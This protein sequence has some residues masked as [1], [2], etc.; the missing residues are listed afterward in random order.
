MVQLSKFNNTYAP[1]GIDGY[2]L[3][4]LEATESLVSISS[5]V[6]ADVPTT[7]IVRQYRTSDVTTIVQTNSTDVPA[8]T[9]QVVQFAIKSAFY[10]VSILNQSGGTAATVTQLTT[11]LQQ[12][13]YVN[14]DIRPL[15]ATG[16]KV[17]NV[18]SCGV[19][20]TGLSHPIA[21]DA[22]GNLIVIT[23]GGGGG[24][25]HVI[26]D[27]FPAVT[28][29]SGSVFISG[30]DPVTHLVSQVT[31]GSASV[32]GIPYSA[33]GVSMTAFNDQNSGS[34]V[35]C[36][37]YDPSGEQI[38]TMNI[39]PSVRYEDCTGA[40]V[41]TG[42]VTLTG[43]ALVTG[44]MP[45]Y[46]F[47]PSVANN[48]VAIYADGAQGTNVTGGWSYTNT[49]IAG[50]KINWYVYSSAAAPSDIVGS[51]LLSQYAVISQATALQNPFIVTYTRPQAT[52][53]SA[54]WYK[55][56]YFWGSNAGAT[57]LGMKL[58]YS[59]SDP[60]GIHP[61]IIGANRIQLIF[62]PSLSTSAESNLLSETVYL[63]TLMT[64]SLALAGDFNFIFGEY[65]VTLSPTPVVLPIIANMVQTQ[66]A[67]P[68][69]A[70]TNALGSVSVSNLPAVQ[71]VG[72]LF[73]STTQYPLSVDASGQLIIS[74][75]NPVLCAG[76]STQ[77][78]ANH[79]L[80]TTTAGAL[81][82]Q[83]TIAQTPSKEQTPLETD[84]SSNLIVTQRPNYSAGTI[85]GEVLA[86]TGADAL[87][88]HDISK[89]S[90]IDICMIV[91]TSAPNQTVSVW[92]VDSSTGNSIKLA[93]IA[94]NVVN[95]GS[96]SLAGFRTAASS[97][98]LVSQPDEGA[99]T[100]YYYIN[101]K[102]F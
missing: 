35:G 100:A 6:F 52:G 61:E 96:Y 12:T 33:L 4:A 50:N 55:N 82:I 19:D 31:V 60:V 14:L 98:C 18:I 72:G 70:G 39:K 25:S 57:T 101:G 71:T 93:N 27:N 87:V 85:S 49:G 23:E 67:A 9:Q 92:S 13:H 53:N 86:I 10:N 7:V 16:N 65:G 64:S 68:L 37:A 30:L 44:E 20:S 66:I 102:A 78:S 40:L 2:F 81:V 38:L 48:T 3:G 99:V 43:S 88:F 95:N 77:D 36:Y 54:S 41:T 45:D 28:D 11:Y 17:D 90:I 76:Y 74:P 84:A 51:Q 15:S 46:K 79:T 1:L 8:L 69:P 94:T 29:V 42:E 80:Q 22:S 62:V 26:V 91:T 32:S 83:G 97:I 58:L 75:T 5:N 24:A 89:Y 21:T 59:G 47:Y 56:K 34:T 73:N 63:S